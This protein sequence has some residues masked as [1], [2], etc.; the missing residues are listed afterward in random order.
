MTTELVAKLQT[1]ID[2]MLENQPRLT[3]DRFYS[4]GTDTLAGGSNVQLTVTFTLSKAFV[5]RLLKVYA[6]ART[7][8]TYAWIIDGKTYSFN[9][10]AFYMG[11]PVHND[12]KLIMVNTSPV[13]VTI[14]YHIEGWGDLKAGG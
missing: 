3:S 1:L 7:G 13:S 6:D 2:S 14:G 12:I 4:G 5:I 10:V 9:E 11:K 8:V